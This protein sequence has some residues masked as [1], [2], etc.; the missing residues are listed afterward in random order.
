MPV[1]QDA[2]ARKSQMNGC[3]RG[4]GRLRELS[5]HLFTSGDNFAIERLAAR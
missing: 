5:G 2:W 1:R 3:A 4:G